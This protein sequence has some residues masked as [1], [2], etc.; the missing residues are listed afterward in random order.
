MLAVSIVIGVI[1][2][3]Q[4]SKFM[5]VNLLPWQEGVS[6]IKGFVQFYYDTNDG[7]AFGALDNHRWV[8][9]ILSPVALVLFGWYLYKHRDAHKLFTVSLAFVIGG[10]VANMIDR[11]FRGELFNG[12]VV[13]FIRFEFVEFATFNVADC[14]IT[15]GAVMI[16]VYMLFFDSKS[17]KPL[18]SDVKKKEVSSKSETVAEEQVDE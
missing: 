9:M 6:V 7:M 2:F 3:D 14:F 13:D 12:A 1:L 10:G 11:V 16:V 8:F 4:L 18:F 15:V 17:D 5:V